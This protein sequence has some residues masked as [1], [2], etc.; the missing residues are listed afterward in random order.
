MI[1]SEIIYEDDLRCRAKHS[2][3]GTEII[4]DAPLDNNGKGE[5]FSPTDLMA[6]SLAVCMLTIM[7]IAEKAHSFSIKE[8]KQM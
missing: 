3:S 4:T 1:T 6:T 7:G 8:Q 2:S 5:A